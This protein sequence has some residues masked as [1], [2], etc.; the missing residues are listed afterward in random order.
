MSETCTSQIVYKNWKQTVTY[1]GLSYNLWCLFPSVLMLAISQISRIHRDLK[2]LKG[3]LQWCPLLR[4][5]HG[6]WA[7][8]I[9]PYFP[10]QTISPP[11]SPDCEHPHQYKEFTDVLNEFNFTQ[12]VT[13]PTRFENI[14]DSFL[15]DDPTLVKSVEVRP[16]KA[17]HDTVLP[18]VFIKP[19]VNK[20]KPRLMFS[21]NTQAGRYSRTICSCSR[22]PF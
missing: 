21:T 14:I 4:A 19:Q 9:T 15:I 16:G 13:L 20:Q 1:Y 5:I 18:E 2:S 8:L 11:F 6:Y 22:G 7:I 17:D 3:L 10:R 12:L